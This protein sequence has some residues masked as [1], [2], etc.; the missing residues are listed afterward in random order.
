[1]TKKEIVIGVLI[2]CAWVRWE[3]HNHQ[4]NK[5]N[6]AYKEHQQEKQK[7]NETIRNYETKI[8]DLEVEVLKR[9]RYIDNL[10]NNE[11]DSLESVYKS[12]IRLRRR[13]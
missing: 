12:Q 2:L 10:T 3:I 8:H 1:M 5:A 9:H 13:L 7:L 6:E 11:L 4:N